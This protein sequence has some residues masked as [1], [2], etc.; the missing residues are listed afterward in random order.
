MTKTLL[1]VV[2]AAI[3][4]CILAQTPQKFWDRIDE[5]NIS[6]N[7]A[8]QIVPKN[9]KTFRLNG[10]ELKNKLWLA[11]NENTTSLSN[12]DCI[13][14]LPLADGNLQ[15]FK[16]TYSPIME[17]GL[18]NAYPQIKTFSV[19]GIDDPYAY[20]KLD[21][22]EFGFHAMI[23]SIQGNIFID[24]YTNTNTTDYIVYYT[25]D[26]IKDPS[27]VIPEAEVMNKGS[28]QKNNLPG[29][30]AITCVGNNLRTYRL[31]IACT[32]EYAAAATGFTAPTVPQ[33]L[34]KIVTTI[35]RV[36][37]VYETE[38]AVR[39]TLVATETMVIFTDPNTDPFTG[40]NNANI[41]INESQSVITSTIGSANF[42]IGHT[43][44]TGGG[45]LATVGCVCGASKAEGIT[46]SAFPVGDPYDI[47]YVCHEVGHQFGAHH[48]FNAVTSFCSGNRYAP[49]A[50]EPGSGTTI[51]GYAGL[52]GGDN[53]TNNSI[54][55]FHAISYDEIVNFTNSGGGNSCANI[56]SSGN[57]PPIVTGISTYTVPK[58]TPF[59]LTGS[60]TDPQNDPLTYSWEEFDAGIVG[61]WNS[62]NRP[63]FMSYPPI[64]SPSR[65]FPKLNVILSGAMTSTVG[66]YLPSTTQ[67][68]NFRLTARDNKMGGGGVCSATSQVVIANDG[69][70]SVTYPNAASITWS[71][72]SSHNITWNVNNTNIAPV[73]C[74]SVNVLMSTDGGTT[75][76]ITLASNTPN[77]GSESITAPNINYAPNCRIKIES[78]GNIFFDINDFDF[79]MSD[80]SGLNGSLTTNPF[81]LKVSP[82]PFNTVI[83]I[84]AK[85][86]D[87]SFTSI[88]TITDI[89]G[90]KVMAEIIRTTAYDK[91]ID[92]EDLEAGVYFITLKNNNFRSVGRIIKQ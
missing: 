31:A 73:S 67:T 91:D 1:T 18:S 24:P 92:L 75:F 53:L 33:T 90:K 88:F 81:G 50:M 30:A 23:K 36:D 45:G 32:G 13:I 8:R 35:N 9:Y 28:I 65:T 46:G 39:L 62:G 52:C 4:N 69:P 12:S 40:N 87:P 26:F 83:H 61:S 54:P 15:R 77:D 64:T 59:T 71:P 42:D 86:L 51:M 63:Y 49:T 11:P 70:F 21:W 43:F 58:S 60:A 44:S 16:V 85:D 74:S 14:T 22:N 27:H 55:Y 2:L 38:L 29:I 48:S 17:A 25:H 20:G 57:N 6:P 82:N 34:S 76:T 7:G 68:L 80:G 84:S 79:A 47:D 5:S 66:E 72:T 41:L 37:G 10:T 56:S 19:K 78:V 3:M 89:L